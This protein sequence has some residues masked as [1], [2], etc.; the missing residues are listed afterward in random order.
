M[1]QVISGAGR[2]CAAPLVEQ[3]HRDRKRVFVDRLGW[4]VPVEGDLEIDQF[5]GEAAVYLIAAGEDGVHAGSVRLLPTT[6]P[7]LLADVFPH[8]CERGVPRGPDIWEITRLF[9][10]PD[11]PDPRS[12]RRELVLGMVEFAVLNDIRRFT[13]LTHVPYLSSVLAV[14][15]DCE[16]LGLPQDDGGVML[17]AVVIDITAQTLAMLRERRGICGSVLQT[18]ARDAA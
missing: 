16:P 7:H 13:C 3:M 14:G 15:W 1:L 9:T 10:A 11:H 8:L 18:E 2:A 12:V 4:R 6:G 17:G 5:D